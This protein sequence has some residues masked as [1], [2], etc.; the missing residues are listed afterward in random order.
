MGGRGINLGKKNIWG[1][2]P[3]KYIRKKIMW[4]PERGGNAIGILSRWGTLYLTSWKK[5]T[6][7]FKSAINKRPQG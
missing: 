1:F 3:T 7:M 6:M 4:D 2:N 5:G